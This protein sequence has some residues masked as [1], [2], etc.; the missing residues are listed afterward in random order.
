MSCSTEAHRLLLRR[1]G[2]QPKVVEGQ[3]EDGPQAGETEV[4]DEQ[5]EIPV[6]GGGAGCLAG[7]VLPPGYRPMGIWH[8]VIP[9]L[10]LEVDAS[11]A[12]GNLACGD[13]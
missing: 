3:R 11:Q 10:Q 1:A 13:S 7:S 9:D 6:T 5:N 4:E 8:V 12:N 2:Q